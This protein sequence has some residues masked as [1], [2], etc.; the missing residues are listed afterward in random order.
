MKINLS[1]LNLLFNTKVFELDNP[2]LIMKGKNKK[3]DECCDCSD[4]GCKTNYS[5][6]CGGGGAYFLGFLGAAIY[7]I[8]EATGFWAGALGVL[9]ALVWPAF[10]AHKLLGI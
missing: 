4:C 8:Q 1:Y 7:Y 6:K 2:I 9:K 3:M 5:W 10:V